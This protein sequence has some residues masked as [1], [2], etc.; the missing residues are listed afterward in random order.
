V[1]ED[2]F[3]DPESSPLFQPSAKASTMVAVSVYSRNS[4]IL[5]L[6]NVNACT[7]ST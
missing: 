2:V 6:R 4:T 3:V 7:Q 1:Q 5:P